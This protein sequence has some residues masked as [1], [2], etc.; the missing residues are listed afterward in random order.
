MKFPL[1]AG[2]TK[3]EDEGSV[4]VLKWKSDKQERADG[5]TPAHAFSSRRI[6]DLVLAFDL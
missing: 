6:K 3:H 2:G 1:R 5:T 4:W